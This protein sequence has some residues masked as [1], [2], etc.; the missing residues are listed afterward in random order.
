MIYKQYGRTGKRVSA[1]GFGGMRFD[2]SRPQEENAELLLYA[3]GKGINYFD[4]APNYCQDQS[5]DIFGLAFAQ[6]TKARK[7][8]Q[9]ATKGMP[10]HFDTADK[11]RSAVEKSLKRLKVDRID[12]YHIWCI[13][14]MGHYELAMKKGGQYDGLRQCQQEGLIDHIVMSTHLQGP[15]VRTILKEGKMAGVLLGVNILNF[16]YRWDGVAAAYEGGYGVVVMNPLAG[17]AIPN[18]ADSLGF[19]ASPGE[20]PVEAALRFCI[21]CPQITV[22]LNGFTTKEHIDMACR[23]A[24]RCEP[25]S[26]ADIERVKKQVA[27]SMNSICTGCGY[28]DG[29]CPENIPIAPYMQCYNERQLFGKGEEEM[30]EHLDWAQQWGYLVGQQARAEDCLECGQCEEACTQHLNIMGRL[31]ELARWEGIKKKEQES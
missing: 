12:F 11:A 14:T 25:F 19:L 4:T 6:M 10:V 8:I 31:K 22:T 18:H 17:G 9:V 15:A 26:E 29:T 28:C 21:S 2:T 13:R 30:L 24:N 20:T 23:V 3:Q 1:V 7:E 5:E 16:P 27:E